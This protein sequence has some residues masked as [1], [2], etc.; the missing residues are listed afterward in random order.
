MASNEHAAEVIGKRGLKIKKIAR[1]TSTYIKCPSPQSAPIFEIHA[2]RRY[3]ILRA[4][5]QIK[6]HADHFDKMKNKKRQLR[7]RA[8]EKIETIWFQKIDVACIIGKH[9]GQVKK[10]MFYSQVKVIS[11]DTNKDP[12]F[13]VCGKERNIKVCLFWMK[14]TALTSSGNN[15]FLSQEISILND[16]LQAKSD[17]NNFYTQHIKEIVNVKILTERFNFLMMSNYNGLEEEK[18]STT[19]V[20]NC[21]KCKKNSSKVAKSLCGHVISCDKCIAALYVDIYLKCSYCYQKI[22]SFLIEYYF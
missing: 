5:N 22:E 16:Y 20:Y 8:D 4:K 13:I 15:Y 11:P 10:I 2:H 7:L 6:I 12:I 9:G 1:D 18:S 14:L 17:S 3:Q 19:S 21:W